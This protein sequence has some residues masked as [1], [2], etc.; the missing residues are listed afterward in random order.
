MMRP[1]EAQTCFLPR[2]PSNLGAPLHF[3]LFFTLLLQVSFETYLDLAVF[4]PKIVCQFWFY[5]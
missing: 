3:L 5:L 1:H 4:S 2:A